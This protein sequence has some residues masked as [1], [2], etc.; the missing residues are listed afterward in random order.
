MKPTLNSEKREVL[1]DGK[2]STLSPIEYM[3]LQYLMQNSGKSVPYDELYQAVWQRPS[4]GDLR[5]LFVHIRHLRQY[6]E[7]NPSEPRYILTSANGG[8]LFSE[9]G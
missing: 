8:Y 6:I 2:R 3:L 5:S 4:L 9:E 1:V 7:A